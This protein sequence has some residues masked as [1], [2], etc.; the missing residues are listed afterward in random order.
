MKIGSFLNDVKQSFLYVTISVVSYTFQPAIINL[1]MT[2]T[3]D[4]ECR[5]RLR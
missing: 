1:S 3:T 4:P 5:S 2:L